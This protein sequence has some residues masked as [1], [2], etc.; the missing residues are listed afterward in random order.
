MADIVFLDGGVLLALIFDSCVEERHRASSQ[1]TEHGVERGVAISDHVRPERR[2]LTLDVVVSDTPYRARQD[3]GGAVEAVEVP[4]SPL[5]VQR[6]PKRTGSGFEPGVVESSPRSLYLA[7]FVADEEPTR[8]VDKWARLID[9]RD[10]ALLATITTKIETYSDM[11]LIEALTTRTAAD[12]TWLRAELTFAQV[13]QVSTQLVDDPTPARVRDRR[14][15]NRGA[16][17]T[18]EAPPRLRSLASRGLE[19]LAGVFGGG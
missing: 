5:A 10:R 8:V 9:A 17:A 7:T 6:A 4:V 19:S 2:L 11:V 14:E 18:T 15:V 1:A 16:Q 12:A 3:V 13:L